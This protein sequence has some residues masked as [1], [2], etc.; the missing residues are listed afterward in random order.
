M[1]SAGD[2]GPGRGCGPFLGI[3]MEKLRLNL[4]RTQIPVGSIFTWGASL[5]ALAGTFFL[6][7]GFVNYRQQGLVLA[8]QEKKLEQATKRRAELERQLSQLKASR[9]AEKGQREQTVV[10]EM[11]SKR[12]FSWVLFFQELEKVTPAQVVLNGISFKP[13]E[14]KVQIA[15]LARNINAVTEYI[16]LLGKSFEEVFLLSQRRVSAE[17]RRALGGNGILFEVSANL[18]GRKPVASAAAEKVTAQPA[19]GEVKD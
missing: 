17:E 19:S 5:L 1:G 4:G 13:G 15:A 7:Y 8:E 16:D 3:A 6:L 14:G 11:A 12:T 18:G 10:Q 2:S 9:T